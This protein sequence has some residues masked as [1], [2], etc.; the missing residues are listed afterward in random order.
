MLEKQIFG[1][2]EGGELSD[3]EEL[4]SSDDESPDK[5]IA[6]DN[7]SLSSK[8][9]L[10]D[11]DDEQQNKPAAAPIPVTNYSQLP[12]IPKKSGAAAPQRQKLT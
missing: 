2:D 8:D 12:R 6:E 9:Q 1:G 11:S 5:V 7:I 4:A 10:S 3:I